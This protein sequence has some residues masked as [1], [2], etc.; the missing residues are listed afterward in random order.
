M[1]DCATNH[2]GCR[3]GDTC[4]LLDWLVQEKVNISTMEAYP[5]NNDDSECKMGEMKNESHTVQVD[6]FTCDR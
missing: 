5:M 1:I 3:G 6:K 4:N 2:N